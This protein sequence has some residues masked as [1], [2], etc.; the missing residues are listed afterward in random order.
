[1][2][3]GYKEPLAVAKM[4][5][6]S[7]FNDEGISFSGDMLKKDVKVQMIN[8]KGGEKLNSSLA[9]GLI[10]GYAGNNPFPA[11]GFEQGMLKIVCSLDSLPGGK[12][13]DMPCCC[14]AASKKALNEKSEA[15][16]CL[17]ALFIQGT[18][19]VNTNLDAAVQSACR[20]LGTSEKVERMSIPTSYYSMQESKEWQAAMSQ[21][22]KTMNKLQEIKGKLKGMKEP[23]V[24]G[25]VYDF[26]LL[27]NAEKRLGN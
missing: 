25:M 4:A 26:S 14:I 23:D 6:E 9:C 11:I 18:E 27:Y 24:A 2:R 21:W 19:L 16:T 17:L 15:I 5:I 8:V 3:I 10:D 12:L 22:L 1:M 13:S 7:A 20:W